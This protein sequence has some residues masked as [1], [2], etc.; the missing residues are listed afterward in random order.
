MST[1]EE[2]R[3]RKKKEN[4]RSRKW[5]WLAFV[6]IPEK[7]EKN[8]GLESSAGLLLSPP[9]FLASNKSFNFLWRRE[10]VVIYSVDKRKKS[11]IF[12]AV[13]PG[14]QNEKDCVFSSYGPLRL[15]SLHCVKGK[16]QDTN[17]IMSCF[18]TLLHFI[19]FENR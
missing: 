2:F 18:C 9:I 17:K 13:T 4:E 16:K 3:R 5:V 10:R 12:T 7:G 15:I 19:L 11:P 1:K 6:A 8:A 14:P